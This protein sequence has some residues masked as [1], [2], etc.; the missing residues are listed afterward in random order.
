MGT[1]PILSSSEVSVCWGNAKAPGL[2]WGDSEALPPTADRVFIFSTAAR[3]LTCWGLISDCRFAV[4]S[5]PIAR[6]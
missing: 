5:P 6:T 4:N 2:I 1:S 3:I